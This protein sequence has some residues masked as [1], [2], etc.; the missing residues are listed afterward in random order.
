M[1]VNTRALETVCQYFR[2]ECGDETI[3]NLRKR[4]NRAHVENHRLRKKALQ[5]SEQ[6]AIERSCKAILREL[7]AVLLKRMD[8]ALES[9]RGQIANE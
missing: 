2:K 5:L 9:A 3:A 1:D 8:S 4:I 6:L 7:I